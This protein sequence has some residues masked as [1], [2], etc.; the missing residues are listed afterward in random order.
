MENLKRIKKSM[1]KD[2]SLY[3][4][5]MISSIVSVLLFIADYLLLASNELSVVVII[6]ASILW[7]FSIIV[8]VFNYAKVFNNSFGLLSWF[9]YDWKSDNK[10]D[11]FKNIF[12]IF[13]IVFSSAMPLVYSYLFAVMDAVTL[14]I[15][16]DWFIL[17]GILIFVVIICLCT[18]VIRPFVVIYYIVIMSPEN[19]INIAKSSKFFEFDSERGPV[20]GLALSWV[21]KIIIWRGN[22]ENMIDFVSLYGHLM[23]K[24]LSK[25]FL[26]SF[27]EK[28][29]KDSETVLRSYDLRERTMQ[30]IHK[31]YLVLEGDL[32]ESLVHLADLYI[33]SVF[34]W[35]NDSEDK[36]VIENREKVLY[37]EIYARLLP[38]VPLELTMATSAVY[39]RLRSDQEEILLEIEAL[40]E[41]INQ[42]EKQ[43]FHETEIEIQCK[44]D[45]TTV[46]PKQLK[47]IKDT[48]EV[49]LSGLK[50]RIATEEKTRQIREDF[51][52]GKIIHP[53][54]YRKALHSPLSQKRL[55]DI[56]DHEFEHFLN[57]LDN[58]VLVYFDETKSKYVFD[59][60]ALEAMFVYMFRYLVTSQN[61][62][63]GNQVT[64]EIIKIHA[65]LASFRNKAINSLI[66]KIWK[67]WIDI[68]MNVFVRLMRTL[69]AKQF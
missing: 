29:S 46:M 62:K 56:V 40:R 35:V 23:R 43:E 16:I 5:F 60:E 32:R 4:K 48:L 3:S 39:T 21:A 34:A 65:Y 58:D 13:M 18:I 59:G 42:I 52:K 33:A 6:D 24:Y 36:H 68:D 2:W 15:I 27:L 30:F 63:L 54:Y 44:N 9:S 50:T 11:I 14:I 20:D 53:F 10:K 61:M 57:H 47:E 41:E 55:S 49:V 51:K 17:T 66:S 22:V 26:Q 37:A 31:A 45:F 19:L 64:E 67:W 69:D 1:D 7:I 25:A 12:G 38:F 8:Y 28:L